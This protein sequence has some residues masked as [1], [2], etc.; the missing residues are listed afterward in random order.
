[1]EMVQTGDNMT[2]A[3]AVATTLKETSREKLRAMYRTM[4]RIR[5]TEE[6]LVD[7]YPEQEIRCPT[8][9]YIGQEA[10]A[11]GVCVNLRQDDRIFSTYRGHGHYLAKGGDLRALMAEL[12]GK[13]TGC[14]KGKGG[15]MHLIQP[16][17]G[18]M[19]TSAIVGGT[20]PLAVGTALASA[21]QGR[22]QASVSFFGDGAAEE[23]VLHESLNFAALKKLP[24]LFVC[25]NNFYATY[26]HQ[27]A[28]QSADSIYRRAEAYAVPG[29]RVDGNDVLAVFAAAREAVARCRRGEGP[30]LMECRTYRWRDH[31]GPN[32]DFTVGY[33]TKDEV[34]EWMGRC[35]INSFAALLE[36]HHILSER[37]MYKITLE[38]ENEVEDAVRFAK[39]S[40]FPDR[41]EL[42]ED[43]Y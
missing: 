32:F 22:D 13:N 27:S 1:M 16:E 39:E 17:I 28:R 3:G 14:A 19:G 20:I 41:S 40:P 43:V 9:L 33:R 11:A 38:V 26:S 34:D 31:V 23:G 6:K 12:Y 10:V 21:M 15:S 42:A 29:V 25:E 24:V 30:T 35:P 7:L 37:E 8:H 36:E 4:V 5:K 2:I 18:M